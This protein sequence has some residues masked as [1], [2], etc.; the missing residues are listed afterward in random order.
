M[1]DEHQDFIDE[2]SSL[3][4]PIEQWSL[5]KLKKESEGSDEKGQN[6]VIDDI[7]IE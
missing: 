5:S 1:K 7:G 2:V 6:K 4:D 3:R